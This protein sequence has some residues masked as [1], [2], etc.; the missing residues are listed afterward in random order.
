MAA[1]A[2]LLQS[3]VPISQFNRGQAS[4]IFDRL[5]NEKELVVLKNNQPSAIILSPDEYARLTE[6]EEDYYLLLEANARL[7]K[8]EKTIPFSD[9][10]KNLGIDESEVLNA[11]DVEIV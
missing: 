9:V 10:L 11:E 4:R 1:T 7:E 5:S 8:S 2:E 3:L 6:I